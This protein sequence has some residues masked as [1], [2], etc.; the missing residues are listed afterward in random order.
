MFNIG[1]IFKIDIVM[2]YTTRIIKKGDKTQY[3]VI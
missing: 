2:Y 3:C 1:E